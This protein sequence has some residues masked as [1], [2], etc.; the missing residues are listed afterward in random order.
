MSLLDEAMEE[1]IIIDERT[2]PDGYGGF[3]T[4][5]V[6]GADF[7]A[8]IVFDTSM[9]A[10]AAEQNGVTSMYTVTTRKSINLPWHKIFKRKSDGKIFRITSDGTDKKTPESA[11]LDMRQYT[12]EEWRLIDG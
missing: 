3:R 9:Q 7:Y 6:E 2:T 5:Y 11:S 4:E 12:A 10:R 8:A 1:C